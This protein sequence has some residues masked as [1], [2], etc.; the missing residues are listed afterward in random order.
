M[1]AVPAMVCRVAV[2]DSPLRYDEVDDADSDRVN[3][4]VSPAD[5]HREICSSNPAGCDR[6]YDREQHPMTKHRLWWS[7]LFDDSGRLLSLQV[8]SME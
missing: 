5:D 6:S 2:Q 3:T 8:L 7:C 4:V 1:D